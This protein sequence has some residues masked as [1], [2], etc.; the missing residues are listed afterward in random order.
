MEPLLKNQWMYSTILA[1]AFT[2]C[3]LFP[4]YFSSHSD[5]CKM[6]INGAVNHNIMVIHVIACSVAH[7]CRNGKFLLDSIKCMEA[8]PERQHS[9]TVNFILLTSK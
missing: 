9:P 7:T 6:E 1:Y 4:K 3:C 2:L 5:D 8:F